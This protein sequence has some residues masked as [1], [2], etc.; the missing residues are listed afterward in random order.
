MERHF[1][2]LENT[3]FNKHDLCFSFDNQFQYDIRL[4]FPLPYTEKG[5]IANY[6]ELFVID[7]ASIR[8]AQ[9]MHGES[10]RKYEDISR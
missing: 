9:F 1:F 10:E 2:K 3:P 8:D 4:N 7:A 5:V 6:C